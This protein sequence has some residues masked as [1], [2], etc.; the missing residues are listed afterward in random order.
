MEFLEITT[1]AVTASGLFSSCYAAVDAVTQ[2]AV[3]AVTT[4]AAANNMN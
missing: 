4:V 1:E 2:A 3:A